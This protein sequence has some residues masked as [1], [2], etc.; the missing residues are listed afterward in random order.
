MG[1]K[2]SH[3]FFFQARRYLLG[4]LWQ[5]ERENKQQVPLLLPKGGRTG[6]PYGVR[7]GVA[8]VVLCAGGK[9]GALFS[10]QVSL[11]W[12]LFFDLFIPFV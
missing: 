2:D 1:G 8:Q 7:V 9:H 6:S 5:Q 11:K 3:Y 4:S 12:H 10:L